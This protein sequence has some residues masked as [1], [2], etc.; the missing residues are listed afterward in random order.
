MMKQIKRT[1]YVVFTVI[2]I[3]IFFCSILSVFRNTEHRFLKILDFPR[4]QFIIIAFIVFS[5]ILTLVKK[6]RWYDYLTVLGLLA[7]ILINGNYVINY[8]FL[9]PKTVAEV[10]NKYLTSDNQIS[11]LIANVKMTNRNTQP[12]LNLVNAVK[13]DVIIAMEVD[14]WW[15][16]AIKSIKSQYPYSKEITNNKAYGMSLYSNK[17][18]KD[19]KINYLTNPNVPSI[20]SV[21]KLNDTTDVLLYSVHP[22]PP[23]HFKNLPD[24]QGEKELEIIKLGNL[25][26]NRDIPIIVAGDFN[27]VNWGCTDKLTETKDLLYDIRVGRGFYNSYNAENCF[28]RWPLDHVFVTEEWKLVKISRLSTIGSDHYPMYYKLALY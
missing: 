13:P 18:L 10:N 2:S 25:I 26:D 11:L 9:V 1:I 7:C 27:D 16:N 15:S 24:N 6:W 3:I 19:I 17:L 28:M 21:V 14:N 20:E 4:I 8:T 5:S 12:F 22:V 23:T